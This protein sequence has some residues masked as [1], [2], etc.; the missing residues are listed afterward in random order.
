MKKTIIILVI[1]IAIVA[2]GTVGWVMWQKKSADQPMP[3]L[4]GEVIPNS[5]LNGNLYSDV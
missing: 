2:A 3:S 4:P 1:T 5:N